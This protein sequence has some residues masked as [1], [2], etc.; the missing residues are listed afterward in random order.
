MTAPHSTDSTVTPGE[1]AARSRDDQGAGM[2]ET[3]REAGAGAVGDAPASASPNRLRTGRIG[4]ARHLLSPMQLRESLKLAPQ[5]WMRIGL[6]AGLQAALAGLIALPLTH[7]SPWP[8]LIGFASLGTLVALFGRF[9][10]E[11]RRSGIVLQCAGWQTFA[12][13]F[14]SLAVWLGA[15]PALQILLL[16]LA[17]G[18]FFF[19]C[20]TGRYGAPGPLIFIFAA[21]AAMGDAIPFEQVIERSMATASAALLAWAI[22]TATESFRRNPDP[23]RPMP[24]ESVRPLRHRLI[25][26]ARI[27]LAATLTAFI[28]DAS[29]ADYPGWAAMG[30]VAVMQGTHLHISMNRALQRMAGTIVGA[31]LIG[32]VIA[33]GPDIW[34]VIG[35][36]TVL[37]VL[38]EIIIGANYGLAQVLIAP[39][40]L[41]MTYLAGQG[42]AGV[43]LVYERIIDTLIGA[44]IGMVLAVIASTLDDRKYLA[45][46]HRRRLRRERVQP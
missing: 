45:D 15:P 40:A 26:S 24:A 6:L 42:S 22:C 20:A 30:A 1:A 31:L 29:G 16:G 11:A 2:A 34:T 4:A 36:L 43:D 41:L 19:A 14:M 37:I 32:V 46:H 17:S 44:S 13:L 5:P 8:H 9:A 7:L 25:A 12:V 28:A 38:T 35:L 39:M 27:V 23:A 3:T 33:Q 21:S 18:L 10:P